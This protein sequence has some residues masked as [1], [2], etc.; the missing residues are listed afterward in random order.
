MKNQKRVAT[1]VAIEICEAYKLDR[2]NFIACF[3]HESNIYKEVEQVAKERFE[4]AAAMEEIHTTKL[5]GVQKVD[6]TEW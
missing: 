3:S 6:Q 1:V 4:M 2:N 5:R